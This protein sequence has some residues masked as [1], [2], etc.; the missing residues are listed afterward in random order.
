M[1]RKTGAPLEGIKLILFDLDGTLRRYRPTCHE[2]LV[3]LAGEL[4]YTFA[5]QE[6]Q[7]GLRWSHAYWADHEQIAL[8]QQRLADDRAFWINYIRRYLEA[9]RLPAD[10]LAAVTGKVGERF[11][12]EYRPE[13]VL[14]PGARE[15]MWHLRSKHLML[16]LLSNRQE[17]L[18]GAAIEL[19]IIEYLDFTLAAGQAGCRKPDPAI[20]RQALELAGH[21]LPEETI[22]VGDNYY[23][24]VIGA[25]RAGVHAVL[26]DEHDAF[27]P[28]AKDCLVIRQLPELAHLIP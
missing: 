8:D 22:Y 20:F 24:D 1:S 26:L 3:A 19:G 17:P 10:Q 21:V 11:L 5:A 12:E 28:L 14:A 15:V 9:M 23:T 13:A 16:G 6:Q 7:A 25:R 4:G 27:A 18:T 2:T